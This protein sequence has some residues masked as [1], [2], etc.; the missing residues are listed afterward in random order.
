MG[1]YSK[2]IQNARLIF[3]IALLMV[4]GCS[5]RR[6]APS[7][8]PQY[9]PA[10]SPM[11]GAPASTE[12]ALNNAPTSAAPAST[13][14]ALN[15]MT[16][17]PDFSQ[18]FIPT[19]V[20]WQDCSTGE[21]KSVKA[22]AYD[23]VRFA[24]CRPDVAF[25]SKI[26]SPTYAIYPQAWVE[27]IGEGGGDDGADM[28]APP[29]SGAYMVENWERGASLALRRFPDSW[30]RS[31]QAPERLVFRWDIE[32]AARL[33]ELQAGTVQ[34]IDNL[35]PD[36]FS[37]VQSDP[38]ARFVARP[39]LNV[40]Y[41]GMNT[42]R[43]PLDQAL[44]RQALAVSLDRQ[45]LVEKTF[46]PGYATADYFAPCSLPYACLGQPWPAFDPILGRDL[47]RQAGYAP[48]LALTLSYRRQVRSYL[49]HPAET[50]QAIARQL[51]EHLGLQ[52]RLKPMTGD[53]FYQALDAG[54]LEG[55]Y[56][57]GW[58]ADFP[59]VSNFLDS[60]FGEQ[61][62]RQFGAAFPELVAALAQGASSVDATQRTAAYTQ[63]NDVLQQIAPL[64]PLAHGG[65]VT[66]NSTAVAFSSQV[67]A[68]VVSALGV[69]DFA[70]LRI[71]G[72]DHFVWMQTAE[73]LSLY[74]GEIL[75]QDVD[76]LRA[77]AQIADPLYSFPSGSLE[78]VPALAHHCT[79]NAALTEWTCTLHSGILFQN[80]AHLNAND[81]V[82]S[83]RQ[84]L[85]R[86]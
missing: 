59:D 77:C 32:P 51:E 60:H 23:Q 73:P 44:L 12:A 71:D 18:G 22:L 11:L 63:A 80:G 20:E 36:D 46:P 7:E 57:L 52:V 55:L 25:L 21:F 65:W 41:L 48:G 38:S 4:A 34:G 75:P 2:V 69:E 6:P 17:T 10:G 45:A 50:A 42:A 61:A 27:R 68:P 30:K 49:P 15:G 58:G 74:C 62:G 82:A 47:L 56:L 9:A 8:P 76:S 70:A 31:D 43:P 16:P 66:V 37:T 14:A 29:G 81:V 84:A 72:S 26:A 40:A 1:M 28:T 83:F 85:I 3:I 54:E 35:S 64:I 79:P 24:L 86:P 5:S 19:M 33:V 53:A 13:E 67:S 78:P 39:A